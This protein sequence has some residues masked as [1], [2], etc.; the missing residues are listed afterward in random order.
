[1]AADG[2]GPMTLVGREPVVWPWHRVG[3]RIPEARHA[4]LHVDDDGVLWCTDACGRGR[5]LAG[6]GEI[7]RIS[8]VPSGSIK[9]RRFKPWA[10]LGLVAV[11]SGREP[12]AV[13][14]LYDLLLPASQS[15]LRDA[16]AVSGIDALADALGLAVEPATQTELRAARRWR[17]RD[18]LPELSPPPY[19]CWLLVTGVFGWVLALCVLPASEFTLEG[20]ALAVLASGVLA[21]PVVNRSLR[22]GR[23]MTLLRSVPDAA[24]RKE[25]AV[26]PVWRTTGLFADAR[27]QL[28][29]DAVVLCAGGRETWVPGPARGGVVACVTNGLSITFRDRRGRVLLAVDQRLFASQQGPIAA[30]VTS[31]GAVYEE[32][33]FIEPLERALSAEIRQLRTGW[34]DE[35][36]ADGGVVAGAFPPMGLWI[37]LVGTLIVGA[38]HPVESPVIVLPVVLLVIQIH[39]WRRLRGWKRRQL[40]PLTKGPEMPGRRGRP[41]T[42]EGQPQ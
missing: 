15:G 42:G 16:L 33:G 32:R 8:H 41:R 26:D 7:T 20:S 22:I 37:L 38:S 21:V 35:L 28:G 12:V 18:L 27:L 30:A 5:V 29:P 31:T 4:R 11:W 19:K 13:L 23:L 39:S 3:L 9:T 34:G 24:G 25:F 1:M 14:N 10:D 17:R 36:A 6:K 2:G 40:R